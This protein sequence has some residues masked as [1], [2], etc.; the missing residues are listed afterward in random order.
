M[1]LRGASR[2]S[3]R[4]G[5]YRDRCGRQAVNLCACVCV[6]KTRGVSRGVCFITMVQPQLKTF[7]PMRCAHVRGVGYV[8]VV[9][10]TDTCVCI[11]PQA[12]VV[13]CRAVCPQARLMLCRAV[14]SLPQAELM[15]RRN[16]EEVEG[17]QA[18]RQQVREGRV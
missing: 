13:L 11:L 6:C 14:L 9:L 18:K 7:D 1:T 3:R 2:S 5:A 4:R 10:H 8:P 12:R 16:K 15:Y 17:L